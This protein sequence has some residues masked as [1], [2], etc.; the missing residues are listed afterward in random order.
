MVTIPVEAPTLATDGSLLLHVPPAVALANVLVPPAQVLSVP[1]M[2]SGADVMVSVLEA[3]QPVGNV[4]TIVTVPGATPVT[5]PVDAS[6][7]A[8]L[9]LVLVHTPPVV[10]LENVV[11]R[12]S[13]NVLTPVI[14]AG[15]AF[16]VM[17]FIVRQPVGNV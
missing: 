14:A 15:T 9:V 17:V 4:Y 5:T 11:V 3:R 13:H 8:I 1:E 2:A 12:A 7:I 6:T 16:T 10:A